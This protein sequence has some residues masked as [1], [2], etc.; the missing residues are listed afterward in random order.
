MKAISGKWSIS[1]DA[2]YYHDTYDTA[3][4]A[5]EEGSS[6][7]RYGTF[8]VAQCIRPTQPEELFDRWSVESWLENSVFDHDDYLGEWA[9]GSMDPSTEQCEELASEI[10]PLIAAWLD[11]HALRPTH[12]NIDNTTVQEINSP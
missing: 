1:T 8:F 10:R 6:G 2:E 7:A 12:F 5:I 9:E 4:E 3:E 11:R